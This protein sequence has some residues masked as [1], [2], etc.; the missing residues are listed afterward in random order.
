MY[1]KT[2]NAND[3]QSFGKD[4]SNKIN[5]KTKTLINDSIKRSGLD[6]IKGTYDEIFKLYKSQSLIPGKKYAITDYDCSYR[7]PSGGSDEVFEVTQPA[8]D[9]KYIIL[10]AEDVNKFNL[11]VRYVRKSGFAEII[12]CK[13]TIDPEDVPFTRNLT[14]VKAKGTVFYMKDEYDNACSY[15]FKHVKFRR[16]AIKDITPNMDPNDGTGGF[17]GPYKCSMTDNAYEFSDP[18]STI[19]SGDPWDKTFIPA[20]FAGKWG[21]LLD[22]TSG[23]KP[24]TDQF[25]KEHIKPYQNDQYEWDK[26]LAWQTNMRETGGISAPVN[27]GTCKVYGQC[28]VEVDK[29][30]YRDRYTFDYNGTD[31]SEHTVQGRSFVR[32]AEVLNNFSGYK[33][34]TSFEK[35]P[36][37][38][39]AVSE[40][41]ANH[42][43]SRIQDVRIHS[44]N[45]D[46]GVKY[47]TILL[48]QHPSFQY[49]YLCGL[50]FEDGQ[51]N[52]GF[53]SNLLMLGIA[54]NCEM[55]GAKCNFI[56]GSIQYF[57][58]SD[59]IVNNVIFGYYSNMKGYVLN[60]SILYGSE[61]YVKYENANGDNTP[62]KAAADG[63]Y[64]Y[65]TVWR[66]WFAY[67][68]IGPHQ[69]ASF[70]P[71][72]NTNTVRASYNKGVDYGATLQG[73]SFGRNTWGTTFDYTGVSG[74]L[75][76][77]SFIRC[78]LK[79]FAFLGTAKTNSTGQEVFDENLAK[80]PDMYNCDINSYRGDPN[81][82]VND[83][84][85]TQ[86]ARLTTNDNTKPRTILTV[87]N[88]KWTLL[89]QDGSTIS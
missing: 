7:H 85:S 42:T 45:G 77:G 9:V 11:N 27:K 48:K 79:P 54:T 14:S 51:I 44:N 2:I 6:V 75:N 53:Q 24:Y 55:R 69:Y 40:G 34:T 63:S 1:G 41:V 10:E 16:Y 46:H 30:D 15:D 36:N 57:D 64:W 12:E 56:C 33:H 83:L 86:L 72:F 4:L 81:K 21:D 39:F 23:M 65:D 19:G 17:A 61:Y 47:N 89:E 74:G 87:L 73:C 67:N 60:D 38:V 18:R 22:Y 68:I 26:Y 76:L 88:G 84:T 20:L 80:L 59:Y 52:T 29:N 43:T 62:Y 13:Y 32:N 49:G 35:L 5:K 28:V 25:I 66:D 8:D 78:Q 70:K 58:I 3:L 71:H 37:T 82:I 31:A 50:E